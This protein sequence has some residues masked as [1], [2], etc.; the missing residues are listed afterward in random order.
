MQC[1]CV[2]DGWHESES[3]DVQCEAH[4]D[5]LSVDVG[6]SGTVESVVNELK[7]WHSTL[8]ELKHWTS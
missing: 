4:F 3:N 5:H 8:N 7:H 1:S 2:G 6:M